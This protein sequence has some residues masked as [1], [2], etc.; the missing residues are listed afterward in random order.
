[1]YQILAL[2]REK[3]WVSPGPRRIEL[4]IKRV[5][6]GYLVVLDDEISMLQSPTAIMRSILT[7]FSTACIFKT[8][9]FPLCQQDPLIN[10]YAIEKL[11]Y[12]R[13]NAVKFFTR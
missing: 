7:N 2:I 13:A 9:H 5:D 11:P 1:M 10:F 6:E 4:I 8:I 3:S 12:T